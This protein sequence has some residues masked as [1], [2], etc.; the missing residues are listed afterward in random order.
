MTEWDG[1]RETGA[2]VERINK[3]YRQIDNLKELAGAPYSETL[4]DALEAL[5]VS[6]EE[7][8]ASEEEIYQQNEEL[9][10]A[11]EA[12]DAE[13]R[14]YQ[15]LFDLA[16]VS[17]LVT[18]LEGRIQEANQAAIEML[19]SNPTGE[20]LKRFVR[21]DDL[22]LAAF[23]AKVEQLKLEGQIQGWEIRVRARQYE[24]ETGPIHAL[25]AANLLTDSK[26][27]PT[28][29]RWLIRDITEL[30]R[31]HS[32]LL[33]SEER[34]RL[35]VEGVKDYAIF[36]LDP[37]G[38]VVT[39][40][41][42]AERLKGYKS[43][44]IIGQSFSRFYIPEDIVLGRPDKQLKAARA[45]GKVEEEGWR[46]RKDGSRFWASV[47]IT[48]LHDEYGN[49]RGFAKVTRDATER[50]HS[51]ELIQSAALFPEE[52]PFPV[53]RV[54]RDG[55]LLYANRA[56]AVLL[57]EWHCHV[58]ALVPGFVKLALTTAL[59]N[60]KSRELEIHSGA[61]ELSFMLVPIAERDYVNLYGSDITE[62]KRAEEVILRAKEEWERTF[63]TVPDLVAILDPQHRI[64][65]ANQAMADRLGVTPEQCIG[66]LCY[67]A[68]HGQ[69]QPPEFCPHALT[70]NDGQQHVAEVQEPRLGGDFL[71]ST[72][73]LCDPQGQLIGAVHVARDIT[74]RKQ[75]EQELKIE[76]DTLLAI[77]ENTN[78]QIAYLDPQLNFVKVNPPYIQGCG[79]SVEEL[80]GRNHFDLFPNAENEAI[81]KR[82][83]E[84]GEP[85]W[86]YAK[87][88]EYID[89]SERGV[90]YWDWSLVPVK[91]D[92]GQVQGLVFSL[93]D[94]TS[95]KRMEEELRKSR[96]DLEQKVQERT[97]DLWRTK[98]ELEVMNEELMV[99]IEEH[100]KTEKKLLRAK[101]EAEEAAK[102]KSFFMANMSHEIRTPMNAV[103][104]M[105]SLLLEEDLTLEQRDYVQIIRSGGEALMTVINDILDFSKMEREKVELEEQ[106]FDLR[107]CIEEALDL[108]AQKAFEKGLEL[109]YLMEKDTPE[110]VTGDPARLRQILGN[111][112]SNAVKFTN[113]GEVVVTVT[114]WP[115]DRIHFAV[116]DTGIGMPQDEIH[117]LFQP[118]SQMDMSISRGYEGTGLGLAISK[119]LAELMG[120]RIWVESEVGTGSTF[121]FTIRAK[122]ASSLSRL[123]LT[124]PQPR[125]QGRSV[126]IVD[127][128]KT[129]RRILGSLVH[130]WGMQPVI[131]TSGMEALGLIQSGGDFDVAILDA[132]M[133][134]MDGADLA[135]KVGRHKEG[136][137]GSLPLILLASLGQKG[138]PG[139]FDVTLTKPVKPLQL[140]DA[141]AGVLA[142]RQTQ[143]NPEAI[144][145][146]AGCGPLRILL[147][148]DNISNQK[149][150]LKM[151]ERLGYRAD[152][153][154]N[155][156]EVLEALERQPYDV[157]LMD[158]R[159][160]QMDGIEATR[161]IRKRWPDNGPRIIAITAYA[162][163]GDRERCLEAGMDD[164]IGKPV[165]IEDLRN[166]LN[167][168]GKRG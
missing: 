59:D 37:E 159:M 55:T 13:R 45:K 137:K 60:G 144:P 134:E 65:R 31:A 28:G 64:I 167:K 82:V 126:L 96:D 125:L 22:A 94:V 156:L 72:T 121:H 90:T 129:T 120:G 86:F 14:R 6:L 10:E 61:R 89:Q 48:A 1:G 110:A 132:N 74:E 32:A 77:M 98:E 92:A 99:E 109:A 118:F 95:L 25:V 148:E 68:I 147:A 4:S 141:L 145:E 111:L 93:L 44:E 80:I 119:K 15:E 17:Y 153:L 56:A 76:K 113:E 9:M 157:V 105:T 85:V 66:L 127:D 84:T 104:G 12:L 136:H 143:G 8:A 124:G 100:E 24:G 20:D 115:E 49:L 97:A 35:L 53:L 18:D 165:Q 133:P 58:G 21:P 81:F 19:R 47:V 78:A 16:P 130:S 116:R 142:S 135:R 40:N 41:A 67:E 112:L 27:E 101:D 69:S 150:T 139:L 140:Q 71:V 106:A 146:D 138:D 33:E 70:C 39:W 79:H 87:P 107:Q 36:M 54:A 160:P 117:K 166:V 164:Y 91:D 123:K 155:G 34:F 57:A 75:M 51:A 128:N 168:C 7:L 46:V 114:P 63:D 83:V 30:K 108:M 73:P 26:G 50:K 122:E 62:R 161:E 158:V 38:R 42:G 152:A 131:A 2:L 29:F 88:F 162:L 151:L 149:V 103:I 163:A 43:E 154:V 52:N 11:Q 5:E 102:V 23:P 3:L